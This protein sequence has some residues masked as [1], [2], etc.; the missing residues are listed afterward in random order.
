MRKK[1]GRPRKAVRREK[2]IAFCITLEQ[3]AIIQGR[4]EAASMS[5]TDYMRQA[6][7]TAEVKA[8]WTEEERM[9]VKTLIG[10]SADLHRLAEGPG[11]GFCGDPTAFF[12][13]LRD[14]MDMIIK[15]LCHDR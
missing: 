12:G 13:A 14:E 10:M 4:L 2:A 8:K 15:Y 1:A 9:M 7:F 3:Y 6:A 11:A 5:I